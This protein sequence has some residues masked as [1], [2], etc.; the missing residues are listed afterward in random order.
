MP[1]SSRLLSDRI[2]LALTLLGGT[3]LGL[4][5]ACAHP[6]TTPQA[7]LQAAPA[8]TITAADLTS[9]TVEKRS[10]ES[11]ASLLQGRTSGVDVAVNPDGSISVRIRGAASFYSSTEPLYV[12]DG[13]PF[14]PGPDGRLTGINPWD[15]ES[16]KVL[17]YPPETSLYGVRGANGVIVITTKRPGK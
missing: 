3:C 15:I 14:T 5:V 10:Q 17:K 12:V 4:V 7:G 16:I 8:D 9:S 1:R 2:A 6:S 13:V 11:I